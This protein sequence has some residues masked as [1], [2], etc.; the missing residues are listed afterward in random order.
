M[1]AASSPAKRAERLFIRTDA[2]PSEDTA[3]RSLRLI[4]VV[5]LVMAAMQEIASR[6]IEFDSVVEAVGETRIGF[7]IAVDRRGLLYVVD[8]ACSDGGLQPW[9]E[10]HLR[11]RGQLKLGSLP[12]AAR[13]EMS[14]APAS[15]SKFFQM[16][17][18]PRLNRHQDASC[19][20][21]HAS[22]P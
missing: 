3:L 22:T 7:D 17:A 16:V 6:H 5:A 20:F 9:C 4:A 12:K 2:R 13:P 19:V 10:L 8:E 15:T 18:A 14:T 21:D 1:D 11:A